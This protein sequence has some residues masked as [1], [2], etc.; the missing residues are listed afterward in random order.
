MAKDEYSEYQKAKIS[1][2]Y[3]NLDTIMLGKLASLVSELY[4]VETEQKEKQLWV[5]LSKSS[6]TCGYLC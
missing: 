4:L 1:S 2:Y 3:T 6:C 5:V